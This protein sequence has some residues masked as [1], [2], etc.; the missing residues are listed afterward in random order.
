MNDVITSG[1]FE[2]TIVEA[3]RNRINK[4]KVAI[5]PVAEQ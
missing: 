1:D 5:K 2:F 3:H 4:V